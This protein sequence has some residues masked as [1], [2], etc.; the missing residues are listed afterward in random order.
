M[1]QRIWATGAI[2]LLFAMA[3]CNSPETVQKGEGGAQE[4]EQAFT[5]PENMAQGTSDGDDNKM[6]APKAITSEDVREI[7][8]SQFAGRW[9]VVRVFDVKAGRN[10]ADKPRNNAAVLGAIADIY[11]KSI[12][13]SYRP[14][15]SAFLDEFCEDPVS[16]ILVKSEYLHN[17]ERLFAPIKGQLPVP[18]DQWHTPHEFLC[19]TSGAFGDSSEKG[20]PFILSK[21]GQYVIMSWKNGWVI[22]LRKM[23]MPDAPKNMRPQDYRDD[24]LKP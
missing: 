10:K 24:K 23:D 12:S 20:S 15:K 18:A 19:A 8:I 7:P 2:G 5:L 1:K 16:A 11:P 3:G 14:E 13:W 17:I 4:K 21:D 22:S 6:T 9:R